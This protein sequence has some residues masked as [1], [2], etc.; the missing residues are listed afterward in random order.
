MKPYIHAVSSAKKFGG[1]PE[2][3][4]PIHDKMD[5]SK[6][7]IPDVRHRAVYHSSLGIYIIEELFG[8]VITNSDGKKVSTRDVAEQHVMED[9]GFIP[10]IEHWLGNIKIQEWMFGRN[11]KN[12]IDRNKVISF[13]D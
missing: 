13:G 8:T 9:L 12:M 6:A 3:Y 1:V 2:D 10:S 7:S 11:K 5:S 4:L